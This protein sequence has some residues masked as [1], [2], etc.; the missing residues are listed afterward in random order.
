MTPPDLLQNGASE[1]FKGD[2]HQV[3][4]CLLFTLGA[5]NA[6]CAAVRAQPRG[7]RWRLG[8]QAGAYFLAWWWESRQARGH[9]T[10]AAPGASTRRDP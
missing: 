7:D 9:Y 10:D 1:E 5:Y 6:G 8:L 4:A 2:V 3:V